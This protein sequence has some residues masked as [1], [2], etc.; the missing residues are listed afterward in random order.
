MK[1]FAEA[2]VLSYLWSNI[3]KSRY[4]WIYGSRVTDLVRVVKFARLVTVI[5]R[6]KCFDWLSRGRFLIVA[7]WWTFCTIMGNPTASLYDIRA[8]PRQVEHFFQSVI[9]ILAK[10]KYDVAR[11]K[12]GEISI[13]VL[14]SNFFLWNVTLSERFS[15][16]RE[17]RSRWQVEE[18]GKVFNL[19]V[20]KA[21]LG[22]I[23]IFI[24]ILIFIYIL[25]D[26]LG[27]IIKNRTKQI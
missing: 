1:L 15:T 17:V 2:S 8:I 9:G 6:V 26:S 4:P 7:L 10:R 27:D 19:S 5:R 23:V 25:C 20:T 21:G 12:L 13:I 3:S 22:N 14:V 24:D 11:V 18:R 16:I